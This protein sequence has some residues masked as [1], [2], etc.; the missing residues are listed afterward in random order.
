MFLQKKSTLFIYVLNYF[1]AKQNVPS[2]NQFGFQ[3][4]KSTSM[5]VLEMFDKLTNALDTKSCAMGIFIDLAKASSK[6]I[7]LWNS[8]DLWHAPKFA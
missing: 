3:N 1:L 8:W 5:A 6:V 7:T 2:K 4:Q